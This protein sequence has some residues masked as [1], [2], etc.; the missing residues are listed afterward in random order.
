V[1]VAGEHKDLAAK[2]VPGR[3]RSFNSDEVLNAALEL[4]WKQGYAGTSTRELEAAMGM[5]QSSI[6]NTYGSKRLLLEAA[7]DRYQAMA[8]KAL[9]SPL[10]KSEDGLAAIDTFFTALHGWITNQGRRGCMLVNLMAEDAGETSSITE[11]T[12]GYRNRVRDALRD[13]LGRAIRLGESSSGGAEDRADLML[14][15][16]LGLNVAAR[17]GASNTELKQILSAIHLQIQSWR[18]QST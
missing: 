3:P 14:A 5:G 1:K 7:L 12:R 4:F 16:V 9:L 15:Q 13:A 8:D 11:R 2:R 18:T 17:G 6:Y 10:E